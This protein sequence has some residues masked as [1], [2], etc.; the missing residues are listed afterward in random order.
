MAASKFAFRPSLHPCCIISSSFFSI[1]VFVFWTGAGEAG[2][3]EFDD[4]IGIIYT[5][6]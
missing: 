5:Y 6:S 3:E 2:R 4:T 1:G